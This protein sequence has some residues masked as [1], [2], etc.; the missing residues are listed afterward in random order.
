MVVSIDKYYL[1]DNSKFYIYKITSPSGKVYIGQTTH[2]KLRFKAYKHLNCKGQNRLYKS[3]VKH[4]VQNHTF[5][6]IERFD[7][8]I[9]VSILNDREIFYIKDYKDKGFALLNL[10][11]GGLN[12]RKSEETRKKFSQAKLGKYEG[13]LNPM[14]GK[15]HTLETRLKISIINKGRKLTKDNKDKLIKSISKVLIQHDIE[16]NFIK[17]WNSATEA[18]KELGFNSRVINSQAR[19]LRKTAYGFIW[20]YKNTLQ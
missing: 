5:E 10:T 14:Y 11:D 9:E 8:D 18:A 20:K 15:T 13:E 1:I 19:G 17:E 16:G 2:I 12:C 4:G 7:S 6:I 3:F